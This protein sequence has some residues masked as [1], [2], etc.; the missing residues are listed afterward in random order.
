MRNTNLLLMAFVVGL[1]AQETAIKVEDG[2][3]L[4]YPEFRSVREFNPYNQQKSSAES[5]RI[6][7]MIYE[8]LVRYDCI[9]EKLEPLLAASWTESPDHLNI[10]FKLRPNVIW[11]DL[12]LFNAQDVKFTFDYIKNYRNC[13]AEI[14]K[15]Y[16][17]ISDVIV[18]DPAT[19]TFKFL[20][21]QQDIL[22]LFDTWIIPK[23]RFTEQWLTKNDSLGSL[24][25]HPVGT[26]PYQFVNQAL[27][28][29]DIDI[30]A[31][32]AH[33]NSP[34]A[35]IKDILM[36]PVDDEMT[37]V[38]S[39]S[40]HKG[41]LYQLLP[42]VPISMLSI[43]ANSTDLS[44]QMY[45]SM[46]I[47]AFAYNCSHPLLKETP[48]RL[49]LTLAL[50]RANMLKTIFQEQGDL[51]FG[52]FVKESPYYCADLHPLEFSVPRA[53]KILDSLGCVDSDG[54]GIRD[55]ATVKASFRL[56]YPKLKTPST[57][58]QE[59][60]EIYANS[61]QEIGIQIK[62]IPLDEDD[63]LKRLFTDRDFEISWIRWDANASS[64]MTDQFDSNQNFIGG[65]NCINY[66]DT[67][68]DQLILNFNKSVDKQHR[69]TLIHRFQERIREECPY[70]F[71]YSVSNTAS[72]IS[73]LMNVNIEP[74]YFFTYLPQWWI[75]KRYQRR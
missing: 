23:H 34:K 18:K 44:S 74:Y 75:P 17:F 69:R 50:N 64:D 8:G 22:P 49:A 40:Q 26:G 6:F 68:V 54:D 11:H 57:E 65:N 29:Y 66:K 73:T 42:V 48:L 67:I 41:R 47:R 53:L 63:Y 28:N 21:P 14:K 27:D 45:S 36:A 33:W 12:E 39:F 16:A 62:L 25:K 55:K 52:P 31:F 24:S 20:K 32:A 38:Q 3:S 13:S 19:V 5:D 46:Q 51:I 4:K 2:G 30:T 9:E 15:K 72:Y 37:M 61:M 71:L 10:T 59:E 35:H 1:F 58:I 60:V 43:V 56:I 70:T 7:V